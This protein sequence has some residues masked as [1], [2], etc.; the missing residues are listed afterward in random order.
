MRQLK[1]F[2]FVLTGLAIMVTLFSLL[3][4]SNVMTVRSVVIHGDT[5]FV[6]SEIR[7]LKKWKDWHPV[8]MNDSSKVIISDPS[9][10]VNAFATWNTN[11]NANK[12]VITESSSNHIQASLMR[13]GENDVTNIISVNAVS[14]STAIQVEWRVLTILK[15]YPWEKFYG[16]VIEK[17]SGPGYEA[18]LNNL[19]NLAEK[20]R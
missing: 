8:F 12:F 15:W 7:D 9:A 17:F 18:A 1:G 19:K 2:I 6:I 3:I 14:D 10:G 16:I 13:K 4:P 5:G 11:G 20:T